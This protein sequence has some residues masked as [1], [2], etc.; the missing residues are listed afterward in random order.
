MSK[1]VLRGLRAAAL[2]GTL[3][4][5]SHLGSPSALAAEN[6]IKLGVL[7]DQSGDFAAATIGKVHA[8]QLA[9]LRSFGVHGVEDGGEEIH[10]DDG[11]R[12]SLAPRHDPWPANHTGLADSAL[13]ELALQSAQRRVSADADAA[14]VAEKNQQRVIGRA[15]L[16]KR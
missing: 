10:G 5:G 12:R 16:V 11:L 3:V 15:H 2:T 9:P 13:P 14:V 6:P 7:E 8:I 1:S 4:L